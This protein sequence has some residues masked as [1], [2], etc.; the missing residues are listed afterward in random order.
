MKRRPAKQ[1]RRQIFVLTPEEKKTVCFV[2]AAFI[3]GLAT[4]HY[5]G[6]HPPPSKAE[7]GI[8]AIPS[9]DPAHRH[10]KPKQPRHR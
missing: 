7:G 6:Q 4:M 5:R 3:L 2:F 9:P 8:R 1:L 10:A